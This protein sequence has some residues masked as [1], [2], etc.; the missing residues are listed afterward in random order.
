MTRMTEPPAVS[1]VI[2]AYNAA[3]CVG[4]AVDSVLAQDFRDCEVIVID[5][6]STDDTPAVLAVYGDAIRV[7][8]QAN[9][10][11]STARNTGIRTARGDF[12]AFLDADDYWLPGKLRLQVELMRSTPTVGFSSVAARVEYPN[13]QLVNLWKCGDE[14]HPILRFLFE[15][16]GGIA[17][18][19]SGLMVRRALFEQVGGYDE[20]L[21]GAEDAD[22]WMRLAAI[23]DYR[24]I[25]DPLV[26]VLRRPGSV[27]R[28][29]EAMRAGAIQARHKN[30]RLL[31]SALQGRFW[32]TSM[33]NV[34][35][36]YSKWRYRAG[37]R[38]AALMDVARIFRL[39][40][41][42]R[43]RLGLGLL[44]DMLL[45]RSL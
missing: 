4:Q 25:P 7:V 34:Y 40:P 32:R 27:S 38:G 23:T 2:P 44:K 15:N 45:G 17:G 26:V 29:V 18:G 11:M 13:G 5:D 1:V 28:N 33:A 10:G 8:H 43:G 19:T 37:R 16:N 9:G 12:V 41:I 30:R 14:A 6:G 3:W 31:P 24:C 42:A 35:A 22:L 20:T 21:Q 36:D 39:A